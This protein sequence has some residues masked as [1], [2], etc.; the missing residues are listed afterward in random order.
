MRS[1][2]IQAALIPSCSTDHLPW[3]IYIKVRRPYGA[4]PW[5][6]PPR[7]N[8]LRDALRAAGGGQGPGQD[9]F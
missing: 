3:Y 5:T 7:G 1:P 8:T 9:R 2:F 4:L 6:A